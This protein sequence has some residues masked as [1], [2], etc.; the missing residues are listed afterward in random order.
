MLTTREY[1]QIEWAIGCMHGFTINE[2]KFI[3]M[4][5]V[6]GL[7]KMYKEPEIQLDDK[8]KKQGVIK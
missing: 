4:V 6:M 2:I 5:N 3:P 1:R 8:L 7:L